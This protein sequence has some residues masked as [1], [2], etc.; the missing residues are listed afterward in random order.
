MTTNDLFYSDV[1]DYAEDPNS[2]RRPSAQPKS[3]LQ[4]R[5]ENAFTTAIGQTFRV[6]VIAAASSLAHDPL[7]SK[8]E[9]ADI[10]AQVWSVARRANRLSISKARLIARRIQQDADHARREIFDE[11]ARRSRFFVDVL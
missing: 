6:V 1:A 5:R 4:P 9:F 8:Y 10:S 2:S 11:E 3:L 7:F